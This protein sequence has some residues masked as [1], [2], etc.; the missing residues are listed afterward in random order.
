[1]ASVIKSLSLSPEIASPSAPVSVLFDFDGTVCLGEGPVL[2]FA[3]LLDQRL[4]GHGFTRHVREFIQH[5]QAPGPFQ[6]CDDPY[7]II[8]IIS[9][10]AG[11]PAS[12]TNAAY[13]D[14]RENAAHS[15]IRTPERFAEFV[16]SLPANCVLAT[17]SPAH[18][19]DQFLH[20]LGLVGAFSSI[21]T[22]AGKP[23]GM[24]SIIPELLARGPVLSV[25]DKWIN[26]L[27]PAQ[28]LGADT[29]LVDTYDRQKDRGRATLRA[30]NLESLYEHIHSWCTNAVPQATRTPYATKGSHVSH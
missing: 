12:L 29:A 21:V 30:R 6:H 19:F 16:R 9:T 15:A 17:N 13:A 4:P 26:D 11:F 5:P 3:Q 22:S 14:S 28:F 25:G 18:E 10:D 27:A 2:E 23:A 20:Q 8:S 24:H 1:M 7:D